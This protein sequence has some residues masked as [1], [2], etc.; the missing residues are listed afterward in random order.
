MTHASVPNGYRVALLLLLVTYAVVGKGELRGHE[1]E[2]EVAV[3]WVVGQDD[4]QGTAW[5]DTYYRPRDSPAGLSMYPH[6]NGVVCES[7]VARRSMD[8][9][10]SCVMLGCIPRFSGYLRQTPSGGPCEKDI[11]SWPANAL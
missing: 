10:I 6:W 11:T 1:D 2:V 8:A 4:G 7:C 5:G 3:W 9:A